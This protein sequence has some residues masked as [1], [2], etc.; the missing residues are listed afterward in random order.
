MK[1]TQNYMIYLVGIQ[2]VRWNDGDGEPADNYAFFCGYGNT[3]STYRQLSNTQ[4]HVSAYTHT[5]Y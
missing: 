1:D 3:I 4:D 5:V 2:E